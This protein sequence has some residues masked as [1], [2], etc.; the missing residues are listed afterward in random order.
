MVLHSKKAILPLVL[1]NKKCVMRHIVYV[2][3]SRK[4]KLISNCFMMRIV[5]IKLNNL[6]NLRIYKIYVFHFKKVH[7]LL[8]FE[9][10]TL[11]LF[12]RKVI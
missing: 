12:I 1:E 3:I 10:L 8:L 5:L 9:E 2:I 4:R 11:N 7:A 6:Y